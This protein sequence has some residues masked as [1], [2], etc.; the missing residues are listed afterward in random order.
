MKDLT[1]S[2]VNP[3]ENKY[4]NAKMP[5]HMEQIVLLNVVQKLKKLK[6]IKIE[7]V[8]NVP[9]PKLEP[10]L[11]MVTVIIVQLAIIPKENVTN[12]VLKKL[13][14]TEQKILVQLAMPPSKPVTKELEML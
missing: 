12:H 11:L 6:S 4:A 5:H 1:L 14:P 10:V 13:F 7:M 2:N 9:E 3:L 8:V